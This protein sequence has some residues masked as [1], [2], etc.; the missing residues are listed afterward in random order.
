MAHAGC[1][2]MRRK[3]FGQCVKCGEIFQQLPESDIGVESVLQLRRY[4]RQQ[5]RVTA[6]FKEGLVAVLIRHFNAGDINKDLCGQNAGLIY[7]RRCNIRSMCS[8]YIIRKRVRCSGL[9]TTCGDCVALRQIGFDEVSCTRKRITRQ[10][11]NTARLS[12][13]E[14][15]FRNLDTG[16]P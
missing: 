15:R 10:S 11:D 8:F 4:L 2:D 6:E 5:K 3:M 16:H 14:A 9:S 1:W 12:S 13:I 7:W